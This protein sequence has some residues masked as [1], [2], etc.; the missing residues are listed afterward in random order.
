MA[1][2][3]RKQKKQNRKKYEKRL[4]IEKK[5]RKKYT[6]KELEKEVK[7]R[8]KRNE[9]RK[10]TRDKKRQILKALGYTGTLSNNKLDKITFK[11]LDTGTFGFDFDKLYTLHGEGIFFAYRDYAGE[12]SFEEILSMFEG[13]SVQELLD[14]L[15]Y[16]VNLA[17]RYSKVDGHD[18]NGKAG[19]YKIECDKQSNLIY[20]YAEVRNINRRKKTREHKGAHAGYQ[21]LKNGKENSF[22]QVRPR[23]LLQIANAIMFNVT[24]WD[25]VLFYESFYNIMAEHI[26]EFAKLLPN[27][28]DWSR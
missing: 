26:P 13:M 5:Q 17:P 1:K 11:E 15:N 14:K 4:K 25:R 2:S 28:R 3:Y 24:E 18:S 23:K 7:R 8:D 9:S 22:K 16:I 10:K 6:Y 21:I 12:L 20:D 27:K 19:D